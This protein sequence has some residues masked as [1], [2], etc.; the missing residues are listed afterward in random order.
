MSTF[1]S[2]KRQLRQDINTFLCTFFLLRETEQ[3]TPSQKRIKVVNPSLIFQL[4]AEA[5][6]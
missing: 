3:S 4:P 5:T 2:R 6:T 1:Q